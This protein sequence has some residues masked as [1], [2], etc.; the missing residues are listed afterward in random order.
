MRDFVEAIDALGNL[1][2]ALEALRVPYFVT[3]SLASGIHG[4]FRATS[5]IDIVAALDE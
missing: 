3:G 2:S 1:A 5:D 4:E